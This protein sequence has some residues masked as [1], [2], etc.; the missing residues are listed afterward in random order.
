MNSNKTIENIRPFGGDYFYLKYLRSSNKYLKD[1]LPLFNFQDY[2]CY[3]STRHQRLVEYGEFLE[4]KYSCYI[5]FKKDI[6]K[7]ENID[8]WIKW[9]INIGGIQFL[10]KPT[11]P[12]NPNKIIIRK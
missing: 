1:F 8:I 3:K 10:S 7:K 2:W 4:F 11:P 12:F 5:F 6:Y 9:M